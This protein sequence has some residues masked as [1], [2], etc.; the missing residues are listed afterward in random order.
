MESSTVST[1]LHYSPLFSLVFLVASL[2]FGLLAY[3]GFC[4]AF[5]AAPLLFLVFGAWLLGGLPF[6]GFCGSLLDFGGFLAPPSLW[7]KNYTTHLN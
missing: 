3:L 7:K 1:Q 4:V 2:S 5:W 6:G